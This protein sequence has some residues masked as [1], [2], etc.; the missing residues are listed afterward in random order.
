[1]SVTSTNQVTDWN[2]F[3]CDTMN[4]AIQRAGNANTATESGANSPQDQLI[5]H[6]AA[7]LFKM[8]SQYIQNPNEV[9]PAYSSCSG[10]VINLYNQFLQNSVYNIL[11]DVQ[12]VN[13]EKEKFEIGKKE[14]AI[15]KKIE[16]TEK[17]LED[18]RIVALKSNENAENIKYTFFDPVVNGDK[19]EYSILPVDFPRSINRYAALAQRYMQTFE[20]KSPLGSQEQKGVLSCSWKMLQETGGNNGFQF[21]YGL[22]DMVLEEKSLNPFINTL[23]EIVALLVNFTVP[24]LTNVR[25]E[26]K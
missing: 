1:M 19:L 8:S 14:R 16:N 17:V 15:Y 18:R 22:R 2:Q 12:S 3:A 20:Y 7:E 26:K 21:T 6:I 25:L 10:H 5:N 9:Q 4:H 11:V 23:G 13:P 24:Q